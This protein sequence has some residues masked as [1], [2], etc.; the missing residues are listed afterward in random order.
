M[1]RLPRPWVIYSL[2]ERRSR[3]APVPGPGRPPAQ[4]A[5]ETSAMHKHMIQAAGEG[6][7]EDPDGPSGPPNLGV[8]RPGRTWP[9]DTSVDTT[10]APDPALACSAS[11]VPA[12]G[13]AYVGCTV[14]THPPTILRMYPNPHVNTAHFLVPN[15]LYFNLPYH[16]PSLSHPLPSHMSM[17]K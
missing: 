9:G 6:E 16:I 15:P 3:P 8:C 13:S 10:L 14:H 2:G 11:P 4:P 5:V 7:R 12:P 1:C 17:S